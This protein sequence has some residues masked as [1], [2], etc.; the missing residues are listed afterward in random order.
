[1]PLLL[2][3]EE[4]QREQVKNRIISLSNEIKKNSLINLK[5]ILLTI[6][7]L[8]LEEKRKII[9]SMCNSKASQEI[10]TQD[11]R[12]LLT[13]IYTSFLDDLNYVRNMFYAIF[14]MLKN[15]ITLYSRIDLKYLVKDINVRQ[16]N[17]TKENLKDSAMIISQIVAMSPM[18][19]WEGDN[20]NRNQNRFKIWHKTLLKYPD[21]YFMPDLFQFDLSETYLDKYINCFKYFLEQLKPLLTLADFKYIIATQQFDKLITATCQKNDG[22]FYDSEDNAITKL[23]RLYE[24]CKPYFVEEKN[25]KIENYF[26]VLL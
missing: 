6:K 14:E 17:N 15:H 22:Y 26:L 11:L 23:T 13:D 8:T 7:D 19:M 4:K 3:T 12:F 20:D 10:N 2:E 5:K 25:I 16:Q 9:D 21:L 18:H 24:I 1:M